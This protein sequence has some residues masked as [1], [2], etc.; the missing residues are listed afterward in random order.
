MLKL[1]GCMKPSNYL[2]LAQRPVSKY[3]FSEPTCVPGIGIAG[4]TP[5]CFR[6]GEYVYWGI[7]HHRGKHHHK[8]FPTVF[9]CSIPGQVLDLCRNSNIQ[10][11]PIRNIVS[12][13]LNFNWLAQSWLQ[14]Y[15]IT[16]SFTVCIRHFQV[17]FRNAL[18]RSFWVNLKR[19]SI[20]N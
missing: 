1:S 18:I 19:I 9:V 4:T 8:Y 7:Q 5:I 11:F 13:L 6:L 10:N 3:A 20:Q 2:V 15:H 14:L 16:S 17:R 12:L